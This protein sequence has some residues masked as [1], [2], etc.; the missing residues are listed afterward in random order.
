MTQP[1]AYAHT[2]NASGDWHGLAH[3][4]QKVA[5]RSR[6]LAEKL[7]TPQMGYYAGLWHDLGKYNFANG[8]IED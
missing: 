4:L 5:A 1:S 3:H 7:A 8:A 6:T 2:P